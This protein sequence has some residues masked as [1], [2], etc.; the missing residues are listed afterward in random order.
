[1]G[2]LVRNERTK[3][4]A[5][6]FNG[7]AIAVFAVGALAPMINAANMQ[8]SLWPV[9]ASSVVICLLGSAIL[10]FVARRILKGLEDDE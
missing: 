8:A 7:V 6:Y 3:L 10:H 2:K 9:V 4:T 5:T 1:M